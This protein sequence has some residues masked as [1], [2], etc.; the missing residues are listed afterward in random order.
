MTNKMGKEKEDMF[1]SKKI[2]KEIKSFHLDKIKMSIIIIIIIKT[3]LIKTHLN[4]Y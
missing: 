3:F 2:K 1:H 4:I